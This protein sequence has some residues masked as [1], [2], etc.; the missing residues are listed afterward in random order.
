MLLHKDAMKHFFISFGS[1][2]PVLARRLQH[3]S[4]TVLVT[5]IKSSSATRRPCK[6]RWIGVDWLEGVFGGGGGKITILQGVGHQILCPGVCY[7]NDPQKGGVYNA[8]ACA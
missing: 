4:F 6:V 5:R 2:I 7:A 8:R 3:S 1:P